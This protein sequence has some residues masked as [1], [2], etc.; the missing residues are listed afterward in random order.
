[1]QCKWPLC[2]R[3]ALS[4]RMK[5]G[6]LL[7]CL[8]HEEADAAM[9]LRHILV[10]ALRHLQQLR[11]LRAHADDGALSPAGLADASFTVCVS[12]QAISA[13]PSACMI[14]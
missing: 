6:Y 13:K 2:M 10:Q 14:S 1:M 3:Q 12:A 11:V 9:Q 4:K 7:P 8:A 5:G